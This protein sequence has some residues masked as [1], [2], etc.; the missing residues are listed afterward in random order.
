MCS[1]VASIG[2]TVARPRSA[3]TLS[4]GARAVR[5]SLGDGAA[6]MTADLEVCRSD[7]TRT[8]VE[9]PSGTLR[10]WLGR[11]GEVRIRPDRIVASAR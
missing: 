5:S 6:V 8:R 9:D 3:T 11:A 2:R 4:A 10:R 7:G 1:T